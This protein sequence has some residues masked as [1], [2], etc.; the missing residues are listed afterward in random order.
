M[1]AALKGAVGP[2]LA[3]MKSARDAMRLA[4]ELAAIGNPSAIS[5]VGSAALALDAGYYAAKLN[6]E[7]NLAAIRD[8]HFVAEIRG[9]MPDD[10]DIDTGRRNTVDM[11]LKSIRGE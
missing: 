4:A 7:I 3:T 5:D 10:G 1:Q 11:V 9:Q 2:P 8:E 6:V